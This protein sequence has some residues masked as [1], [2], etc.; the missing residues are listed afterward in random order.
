MIVSR[1]TPLRSSDTALSAMSNSPVTL[2]AG[3][4][5]WSQLLKLLRIADRMFLWDLTLALLK[6]IFFPCG[7]LVLAAMLNGSPRS[8]TMALLVSSPWPLIATDWALA[9]VRSMLAW[10]PM[11]TVR[12]IN[13]F[14]IPWDCLRLIVPYFLFFFTLRHRCPQR[15]MLELSLFVPYLAPLVK[16]E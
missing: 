4:L 10:S 8:W 5:S 16:T 6:S 7:G 11:Q 9:V 1:L 13:R 3:A 2:A 15:R 14:I 12:V